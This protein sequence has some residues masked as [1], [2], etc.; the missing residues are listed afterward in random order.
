MCCPT[1]KWPDGQH[2]VNAAIKHM[3]GACEEIVEQCQHYAISQAIMIVWNDQEHVMF[4]GCSRFQ[5][6]LQD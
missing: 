2:D 3:T 1:K 4:T 6:H 5:I